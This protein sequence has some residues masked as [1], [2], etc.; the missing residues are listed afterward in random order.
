MLVLDGPPG[1]TEGLFV[2]T[3]PEKALFPGDVLPLPLPCC[4]VPWPFP[5]GLPVDVLPLP[6]LLPLLFPIPLSE[7]ELLFPLPLPV[8]LPDD[9]LPPLPL[10]DPWLA[11]LFDPEATDTDPDALV[12][13]VVLEYML[14]RLT[15]PQSSP[16]FPG[17]GKLH[18]ESLVGIL[19]AI[20]TFPQ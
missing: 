1:V 18:S 14:N 3:A 13:E 11:P 15:A 5:F 9:A 19:P 20:R 7:D 16:V 4:G 10:E 17:Q 8:A 6:L 12:A 2:V